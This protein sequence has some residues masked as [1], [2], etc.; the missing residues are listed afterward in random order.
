M[1]V[2]QQYYC[3]TSRHQTM[4]D[5]N[6]AIRRCRWEGGLQIFYLCQYIANYISIFIYASCLCVKHGNFNN[7]TFWFNT[8]LDWWSLVHWIWSFSPP[9]CRWFCC[10]VT[11]WEEP[12]PRVCL[13]L[14]QQQQQQR[15]RKCRW[16][17]HDFSLFDGFIFYYWIAVQLPPITSATRR[18]K[19]IV[20]IKS[21]SVIAINL[22]VFAQSQIES[23]NG[24]SQIMFYKKQQTATLSVPLLVLFLD[25]EVERRC[26]QWN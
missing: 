16:F 13:Y 9:P 5:W 25:E 7:F 24:E 19:S 18:T 15:V 26:S 14:Y 10:G 1:E 17:A 23:Q 11:W 20:V 8:E 6:D 21:E 4:F 12:G 2:E 3:A 22:L